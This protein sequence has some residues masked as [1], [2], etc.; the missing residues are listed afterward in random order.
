MEVF[1]SISDLRLYIKSK[2]ASQFTVGF[3]ATM[4]ALHEG[5]QT[6]ISA[7][8]AQN[9]ITVC[10]IFVNPTQFNNPEDLKK[11]PR[12]L[13]QDLALLK[14]SGCSAVFAPS[15]EEMYAHM[16]VLSF[17]FGS[18]E[19]VMEGAA[20]PGH[21]NGVGIVVSRLFNIVQPDRAYFGQKD[22]QQVAIIKQMVKDLAFPIELVICPTLRKEDG[23]AMSS[24]NQR[25]NQNERAEATFIY[26]ILTDAKRVLL[27]G[28]KPQMVSEKV[29]DDFDAHPDFT[30]DYFEIVNLETLQP[31]SE[32]SENHTA[33]CIAAYIGP[34]RLIDNI[35]L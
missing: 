24:R 15:V 9:D 31:V 23:L 29:K 10:S 18:L 8:T 22:L 19:T 27:E 6:L 3:V 7:S 5:H 12:N 26:K 2:R 20:R 21:F 33:L 1:T 34:V 16:P 25:L 14:E 13:D 32:I 35:L 11:Y 30:L 4:G 28:E 17:N